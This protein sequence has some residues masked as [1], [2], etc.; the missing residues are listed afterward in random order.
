MWI[1][2]YLERSYPIAGAFLCGKTAILNFTHH[3]GG[4]SPLRL[5]IVCKHPL[6][7]P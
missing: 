7:S 5:G 6:L 1:N 4:V 2:L 3:K